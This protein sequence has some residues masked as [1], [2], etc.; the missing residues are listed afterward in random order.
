ML[1]VKAIKQD[2]VAPILEDVPVGLSSL[3][4]SAQSNHE[5]HGYTPSCAGGKAS[6]FLLA[7]PLRAA[8][9]KHTVVL[10]GAGR[11][12]CVSLMDFGNIHLQLLRLP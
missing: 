7:V 5:G 3:S 8:T 1:G 12:Q 6:L 9:G 11:W 2:Q 4:A 10:K